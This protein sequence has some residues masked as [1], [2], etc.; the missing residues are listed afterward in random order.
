MQPAEEH[1]AEFPVCF[2]CCRCCRAV[3]KARTAWATIISSKVTPHGQ[4]GTVYLYNLQMT[5]K[6]VTVRSVD[7][8]GTIACGAAREPSHEF[9]SEISMF[10]E[11]VTDR[12]RDLC[13]K[14]L[15][16]LQGRYII[17]PRPTIYEHE[18][19]LVNLSSRLR[20]RVITSIRFNPVA[21]S[22]LALSS[23]SVH[24]GRQNSRNTFLLL[25]I[26]LSVVS[27]YF[28]K[29]SSRRVSRFLLMQRLMTG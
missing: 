24:F 21:D 16:R 18:R 1:S 10:S 4:Q 27:T 7:G 17:R 3:L 9:R 8:S 22:T 2:A 23:A 15:F 20:K 5:R 29:P 11:S 19:A 28:A 6:R 26:C 12:R 13:G 14:R 25:F